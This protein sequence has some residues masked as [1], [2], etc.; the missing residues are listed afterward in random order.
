MLGQG[1]VQEGVIS[2][3]NIKHRTVVLKQVCE[4]ADGLFIHRAA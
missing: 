3:Q 1:F 4:E 2:V